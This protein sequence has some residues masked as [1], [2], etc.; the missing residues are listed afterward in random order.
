MSVD[1]FRRYWLDAHAP[2]TR[3]SFAG[4]RSCEIN[5]VTGTLQGDP[6]VNGLAELY[7]DSREAFLRDITSP[8]G[9]RVLDDLPNFA[10]EGG[11]LLADEHHIGWTGHNPGLAFLQRGDGTMEQV[12][13]DLSHDRTISLSQGSLRASQGVRSMQFIAR[14][15]QIFQAFWTEIMRIP[16]YQD[17]AERQVAILRRNHSTRP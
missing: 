8:A 2:L 5:I 10:S 15:R 4:L 13:A 1:E 7:W 16:D 11:P 9:K 3:A 17:E 12:V 14:M 6:F